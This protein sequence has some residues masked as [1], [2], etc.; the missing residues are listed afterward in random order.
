MVSFLNPIQY[1]K[2]TYT[3]NYNI[4]GFYTGLYIYQYKLL[5]YTFIWFYVA[6]YH[7]FASFGRSPFIPSLFLVGQV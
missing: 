7:P 2:V 5:F 1:L 6:I 3:P 4:I